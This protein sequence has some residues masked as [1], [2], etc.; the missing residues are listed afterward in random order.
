MA[1]T[2]EDGVGTTGIR[3][4]NMVAYEEGVK[5]RLASNAPGTSPLPAGEQSA[6]WDAGVLDAAN[7]DIEEMSS[8]RGQQGPA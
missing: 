8:Y 6:A 3:L 2:W 1:G 7:G 4:K 5:A